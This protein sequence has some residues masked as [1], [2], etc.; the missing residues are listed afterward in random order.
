MKNPKTHLQKGIENTK[1]LKVLLCFRC[2]DG[3]PNKTLFQQCLIQEPSY[4]EN[5]SYAK[6]CNTLDLES[7]H[8]IF[9]KNVSIGL[10][11]ECTHKARTAD[12]FTMMSGQF[13]L[14]LV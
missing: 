4:E 3:N 14:C 7:T 2:K 13:L 9:L 12:I 6:N 11:T 8:N 1:R 5:D 10:H